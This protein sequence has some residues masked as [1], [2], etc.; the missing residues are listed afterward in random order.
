MAAGRMSAS[1]ISQV[2]RG[3]GQDGN[4]I[5]SDLEQKEDVLRKKY[6]PASA[7]SRAEIAWYLFL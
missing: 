5:P 7:S 6:A 3:R 1:A 2:M 4:Y